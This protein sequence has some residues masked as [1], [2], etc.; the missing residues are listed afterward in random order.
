MAKEENK[1]IDS[2]RTILNHSNSNLDTLNNVIRNSLTFFKRK[3]WMMI[4]T[5]EYPLISNNTFT[6]LQSSGQITILDNE[7]Q[8]ELVSFYGYTRKYSYMIQEIINSKNELYFD[9]INIIPAQQTAAMNIVNSNIYHQ[10]WN[11]VDWNNVQIKFIKLLNTYY[12]LN[13]KT[14]F[15]NSMRL[16][17]SNIM[18]EALKA[19]LKE[20]EITTT[21]DQ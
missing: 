19:K 5:T 20:N 8:E 4:A 13:L 16:Y 14:Q 2:L 3:D 12:E 10:I 21:I 11:Q 17:K 9:Y 1:V 15:F 18:I 7:L 6:S